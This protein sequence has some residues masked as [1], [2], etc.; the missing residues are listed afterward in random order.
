MSARRI[1]AVAGLLAL[2]LPAWAGAQGLGDTAARERAKRATAKK[3]A[4]AR[5]FTNDDLAQGRPPEAA[6]PAG[7]EAAL[8]PAPSGDASAPPEPDRA[9]QAKPYE[10]AVATASANLSAVESR[11]RELRDRLNPMSITYVYGAAQSGDAA[12]EEMRVKEEL[13]QVEAQLAEAQEALAVAN[14]ALE[15]FRLGRTPSSSG[16]SSA[17]Y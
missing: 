7:E 8:A 9:A 3:P 1:P 13:R 17:P 10:D 6:A 11:T 5:T 15:D 2:V 12:G 14:K 4:E 16:S